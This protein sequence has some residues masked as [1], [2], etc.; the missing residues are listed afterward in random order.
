MDLPQ[1]CIVRHRI[2]R[3]NIDPG[4][5]ADRLVCDVLRDLHFRVQDLAVVGGPAGIVRAAEIR[6]LQMLRQPLLREPQELLVLPSGYP[7]VNVIVPGNK[8][9]MPHGAQERT[10]HGVMPDARLAADR[11]D[12]FQHLQL[13]VLQFSDLFVIHTPPQEKSP[14]I[15]DARAS[16]GSVP[17]RSGSSCPSFSRTVFFPFASIIMPIRLSSCSS[18]V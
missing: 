1:Q 13:H 5:G 18:V 8:A 14:Q 12:R 3:E 15:R 10:A 16:S 4:V 11:E 7:D 6:Q 17:Y 9:L 2:E